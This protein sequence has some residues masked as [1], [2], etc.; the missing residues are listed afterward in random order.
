MNSSTQVS[1]TLLSAA[2]A[3]SFGVAVYLGGASGAVGGADP[4][5]IFEDKCSQ[6]HSLDLPKS[7]RMSRDEWFNLIQR[8]KNNGCDLSSAEEAAIVDYL[9][10]TYP[11]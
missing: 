10:A 9:S 5:G 4:K 2:L 3:M 8:M 7:Q 11:K 1:R 6:C